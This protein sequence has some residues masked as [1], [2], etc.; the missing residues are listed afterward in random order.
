MIKIETAIKGIRGAAY[1]VPDECL[2]AFRKVQGEMEFLDSVTTAGVVFGQLAHESGEFNKVEESMAYSAPRLMD[3]FPHKFDDIDHAAS[4]LGRGP[5]ALASHLYD[6][7]PG[8]GNKR[9]GDGWRYRGSGYIHLT[10]L[11]NF[12]RASDACGFNYVRRPD[13][14]RKPTHAWRIANWYLT[15]RKRRGQTLVQLARKGRVEDVTRG[16][17]GGTNGHPDRL[18][19]AELSIAAMSKQEPD[20]PVVA[21]RRTRDDVWRLQSLLMS[22]GYRPGP[23]DGV[24]GALTEQALRWFQYDAGLV[25]D[26]IAGRKTMQAL[27]T[28]T[29]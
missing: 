12:E 20:A 4:V 2:D 18:R 23:L 29:A 1:S 28:R 11:A 6:S 25:V 5:K 10:G 21:I 17:N 15:S 14:A 9:K 16:I 26:G 13:L 3:V 22:A 7:H 24:W 8:L 19:R 27:K